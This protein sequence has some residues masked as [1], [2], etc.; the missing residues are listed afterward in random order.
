MLNLRKS[1][2]YTKKAACGMQKV[3]YCLFQKYFSTGEKIDAK[4]Q[5]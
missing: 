4:N 1:I 5:Y 2:I 3:K